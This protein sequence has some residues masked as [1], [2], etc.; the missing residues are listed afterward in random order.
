VAVQ[1]SFSASSVNKQLCAD[2]PFVDRWCRDS[3]SSQPT[4]SFQ[5]A[6]G[7]F[8]VSI[9]FSDHLDSPQ[10]HLQATRCQRVGLV[11]I[12]GVHHDAIAQ[13]AIKQL[14]SSANQS[15]DS[16]IQ[17]LLTALDHANSLGIES[18]SVK[19][20]REWLSK[21]LRMR[22]MW[23]VWSC[24]KFYAR[25]SRGQLLTDSTLAVQDYLHRYAGGTISQLEK[26]V[27][28]ELDKLQTG[29]KGDTR[30]H[31]DVWV[32]LWQLVFTYQQSALLGFR[33]D[34]FQETTEELFSKVV[35]LYSACFRTTK[36]LKSLNDAGSTV[37]AGKP[38]V[39]E[40]FERA[41]RAHT[42]FCKCNG[43]HTRPNPA[44]N[45]Q[46]TRSEPNFLGMS[47]SKG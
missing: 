43:R 5:S 11:I 15:F 36:A 34:Q 10:V 42:E 21:L 2:Y 18:V 6:A 13:W 24:K 12:P 27:L 30:D 8:T 17:Q 39:K 19:S 41:W 35:V 37:F 7:S 45:F 44:D 26:D 16:L 14:E 29:I 9:S 47:S 38:V 32:A 25:D 20:Q 31:V 33:R 3:A 22:C 4:S 1:V 46:T 40:A 28:G 23:N